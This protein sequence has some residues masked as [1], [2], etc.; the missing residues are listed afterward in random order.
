MAFTLPTTINHRRGWICIVHPAGAAR[1]SWGWNS[2][3]V[4]KSTSPTVVVKSG[5]ASST[6][7]WSST[8][9][10][11]QGAPGTSS[12]LPA[13]LTFVLGTTVPTGEASS[14][15][16]WISTA[17]GTSGE[18]DSSFP[19]TFPFT[20]DDAGT[21]SDSTLSATLPFTLSS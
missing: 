17:F 21:G 19:L 20:F 9:T 16:G 8:A 18:P 10:G 3:A 7:G 1:S 15:W 2:T 12:R 14:T 5:T 11:V 6:W 4:G 13:T